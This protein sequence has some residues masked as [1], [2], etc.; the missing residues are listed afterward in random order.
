MAGEPMESGAS[1]A[2]CGRPARGRADEAGWLYWSD[3]IGELH[4]FCLACASRE[5]DHPGPAVPG[6]QHRRPGP[7]AIASD[8]TSVRVWSTRR[9]PFEPRGWLRQMREASPLW[10]R[11]LFTQ[12]YK[13]TYGQVPTMDRNFFADGR[14]NGC[15][16]CAKVC[17]SGNVSMVD[18]KPRWAGHCEQCLACLQWCPTKALQ[19]GKKTERYQRYH[20]PEIKV[21]DVVAMAPPAKG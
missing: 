20:H 11:A 6:S 7:F 3:G 16:I 10:Q 2:E 1:C 19:Y 17:P 21:A 18:G 9:L 13:V 14:C 4:A 15:G 12:L 8:N 5:F